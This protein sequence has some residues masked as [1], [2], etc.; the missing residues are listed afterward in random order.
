V[1]K[2]DVSTQPE[3]EDKTVRLLTDRGVVYVSMLE[4]SQALARVGL[5]SPNGPS[6][7]SPDGGTPVAERMAIAA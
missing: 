7:D 2:I 6:I 3:A 5:F 1:F 4:W